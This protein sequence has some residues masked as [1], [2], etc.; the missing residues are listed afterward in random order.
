MPFSVLAVAVRS[1]ISDSRIVGRLRLWKLRSWATLLWVSLTFPVGSRSATAINLVQNNPVGATSSVQEDKR[2]AAQQS[3]EAAERLRSAGTAASLKTALEKYQQAGEL[4]HEVGDQGREAI[5][6]GRIGLVYDSLG[7]K[8][9]A[10]D[11]FNQALLIERA[12]GDRSEE[13]TLLNNLGVVYRWLGETQKALYFHNQALSLLRA[14]GDRSEEARTLN[15]IGMVYGS[16]GELPRALDFF[17]QALP[18][19]RAVSNRNGEATTLINIGFVYDSL[20]AWQKALDFYN[21]ALAIA[22]TVGNR[23]GEAATLNNMGRIYDSLGEKQ[24]ALDFYNQALPIMR[25]VGDRLGE[26]TTLHNIGG[27]Y[28]RLGEKEKALDFYDQALSIERAVSNRSGEAT[29]LSNI[30]TVYN[31]LGEKQKALDFYNQA[32][33]IARAVGNRYGEGATLAQIGAVYYSLG[34]T[35]KALDFYNQALAIARAVGNRS[36]EATTLTNIGLVYDSLGE[37]QKALDYYNQA[38][39]ISRAVGDRSEEAT[40]LTNIGSVYES[41]GEKQKALD[42]YNQALPISRAVSDRSGEAATLNKTGNIYLSLGE[43][44][45]ALDYYKQALPIQR[46]IG[47]R[48]GEAATLSN[49]GSVYDSLWEKQKALDYYSHALPI[50]R[51][52]GDRSGEATTLGN[53]ATLNL[54]MGQLLEA[55][56]RVEEALA[57]VESLRGKIGSGDLRTSYFSSKIGYYVLYVDILMR[58]HRLHPAEGY[59]RLALEASERGKARSLLDLLN[60]AEGHIYQGAD[61]KF[62][63]HEATIRQQLDAQA[64]LRTKLLNGLHTPQQLSE[65]EQRLRELTTQYEQVESEIRQNS[66]RYAA[67]TQPRPASVNEMQQ[68]LLDSDTVLLEYALGPDRSYLWMVTSE[69]FTSYELPKGPDIE[70]ASRQAYALLTARIQ[71]RV[72]ADKEYENAAPGLSNMLLGK[73]GSQ[74]G[75]QRLLIVADG[76]LNYLPFGALLAP[77]SGAASTA[78][79]KTGQFRFVPLLV[80][81]E[82]VQLPSASVLGLLRRET[83]SRQL[84]PKQVFVFADPVFSA[85]DPRVKHSDRQPGASSVPQNRSDG[86]TNGDGATT[87]IEASQLERSAGDVGLTRGGEALPRLDGTREE[88]KSIV[89]LAP[90]QS[91]LAL[92]FEASRATATTA[93]LTQ[94]RYLHFATHGLV[95]TQH[96]ELSGLVLSMV[97]EDGK[98]VNGFLRLQDIFNLN[99]PVELV[100]L[101]ACETG[102]GKEVRGEG[103][104]GLTRGF[105]YAGVPRVVV[106]LWKVDDAATAELMGRFY[107]GMLVRKLRPAAALRAAQLAMWQDSRWRAPYYW[108]AFVLQGEWN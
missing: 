7:D 35:Q 89:A 80:D 103:L 51:A 108:A 41:L 49:I 55:R 44:Q 88:G 24:K 30:G 21:Q 85:N 43:N 61:P 94:Y 47:D 56:S 13:A 28:D 9:K 57:I 73:V 42:Y 67:L 99:L 98:P 96:P 58:L 18:M 87:E 20:G 78:D 64:Q 37:M 102:I 22:R 72:Q 23:N 79:P 12:L 17:N 106:S 84:A 3:F 31:S 4:W 75:H 71:R 5:A 92:D 2:A 15:Y 14:V 27:I 82:V 32:L 46:A 39:P 95:D 65:L 52:V 76:A 40:T 83:A 11:F 8:Q 107:E 53:I 34:E 104:L 1:A 90:A 54:S 38:L 19:W 33:A 62:L 68:H 6:L 105:M 63:E 69:T 60:E 101:S 93:D 81:H 16:L 26:A 10:L 25:V 59:D 36:G 86:V 50:S 100:V 70:Q 29:T 74:L 91:K 45:K 97:N 66:P 77:T 48:S